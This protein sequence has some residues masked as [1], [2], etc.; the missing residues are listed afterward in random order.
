MQRPAN[1][2]RQLIKDVEKDRGKTLSGNRSELF[3]N[4]FS[5][6]KEEFRFKN[7]NDPTLYPSEKALL[8]YCLR[9]INK[10][11]L[12]I[13]D[14][15]CARKE[16]EDDLDYYKVPLAVGGIESKISTDGMINALKDKLK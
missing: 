7:V 8:Q 5:D 1:K 16:K 2:I 10:N 9:A 12:G 11:R 3:M 4:L 15:E 6:N 14:V 13:N